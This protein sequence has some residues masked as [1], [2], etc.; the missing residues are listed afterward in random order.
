MKIKHSKYKNSGILFELLV[1]QIT[2]DTLEGKDSPI[3]E[4]LKKYFV[5]TELGKEYKLYETLL[6][7]TSLTEARADLIISTL[8]ESS[9]NLNRRIIKQQ[10]YNLIS[11][12]QKHYNLNEFFNHKLPHY[13]VQAAFYTL[14]EIYNSS[15]ATNPEYIINN[16]MTI[17]EHLTA[18]Q[19]AEKSVR[20][21]VLNE[22]KKEDKDI[23]IL[24]YKILLEKFN[25]KYD[26]L[27]ESQKEILKELIYS[28][29]NKPRL[30]EFYL[31]KTS[32]L[33]KELQ[34]LNKNV[35]D[36]VTKIK[37]N[38]IIS[39]ISPSAKNPKITDNHLVNLLQYCDLVKELELANEHA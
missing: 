18:A 2:S 27:N 29:D 30:K 9:K 19:I 4:I 3:K 31:S 8:I 39:L 14:L 13:K 38:E 23:R 32:E 26:E 21:N 28:I 1:R 34:T 5:K 25:G 33:K 35:T 22:F 37:V 20:D 6:N 10:K 36:K 24:T 7:K 15:K 12:V 11:E 17:L 16:K